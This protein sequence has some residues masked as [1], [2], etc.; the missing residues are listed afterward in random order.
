MLGV[1]TIKI[2]RYLLIMTMTALLP[3]KFIQS[4][5]QNVPLGQRHKTQTRVVGRGSI[6]Y[7]LR[8]VKS[9]RY[10]AMWVDNI[11][12]YRYHTGSFGAN[13]KIGPKAK[14]DSLRTNADRA[15]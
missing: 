4:C 3:V 13:I 2:Y 5:F 12:T 10:P 11:T 1:V 7:V 14:A 6:K 8:L 9:T 15:R